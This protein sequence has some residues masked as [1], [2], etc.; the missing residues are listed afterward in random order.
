M[1]RVLLQAGGALSLSLAVVAGT[2]IPANARPPV[3]PTRATVID[4]SSDS[5]LRVEFTRRSKPPVYV[6]S[7]AR[8]A[9][10]AAIAEA[11]DDTAAVTD[12][13]TDVEVA[14]NELPDE[15]DLVGV[16]T[17]P[18]SAGGIAV[19]DGARGGGS[20]LEQ[21]LDDRGWEAGIA[22]DAS[23]VGSLRSTRNVDVAANDAGAAAPS[24]DDDGD[25]T[26]LDSED[27]GS[28]SR[29]SDDGGGS[30][31]SGGSGRRGSSSS[32][33]GRS[34]GSSGSGNSGS[35]GSGGSGS[36]GGG[37]SGSGGGSSGHGSGGSDGG[38]DGHGDS[39]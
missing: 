2:L 19:G 23:A 10:A 16:E 30:G 27:D 32:N 26:G 36:S 33:S 37:H 22:P 28:G 15:S 29:A 6:A 35:S 1:S 12:P 25:G 31:Q 20:G 39:D 5:H 8:K 13:T 17:D 4:G 7:P 9:P 21:L 11:V 38:S 3:S 34:G 18:T 24:D 14:L